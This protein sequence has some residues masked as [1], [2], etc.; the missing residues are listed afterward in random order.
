MHCLQLKKV[1]LFGAAFFL[2]GA[3]CTSPDRFGGSRQRVAD[4]S[5]ERGFSSQIIRS[6]SFD[7]LALVRN[8]GINPILTVY[9]EGDG[10][11][12]L[13]A[14]HPPHDP[15]PVKPTA[16]ALAAAD[17]APAVVYLGRPCQYLDASGLANCSPR[18]WTTHRFAPEVVAAYDQA[19]D[20]LKARTGARSL[21]L[22][23]YSGGGVVAALLAMRRQ[24]VSLLIT[25]ASPLAVG[26]WAR[27]KG[28]SPLDGSLDPAL[29]P[30]SLP[31]AEYWIGT[32]DEIVPVSVVE[33]FA[34]R[35]GGSVRR[36]KGYGHEC[37]WVRDWPQ[38]IKESP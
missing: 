31:H 8:A 22:I 4:W 2:L 11:P 12:W 26:E 30:G 18:W 33:S 28:I 20:V 13:S 24:D 14:Y 16:L 6:G 34:Q 37:C 36:A 15:T 1:A 7:L 27:L 35:K 5:N 19:L 9:V 10:A 21:K 38:L 25:L 29:E 3:G 17:P 23:G 32:E